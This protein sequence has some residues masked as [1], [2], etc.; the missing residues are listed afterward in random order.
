MKDTAYYISEMKRYIK[1]LIVMPIILPIVG[2]GMIAIALEE[3]LK[4]F[5]D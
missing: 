3:L 4:K 1:I 2:I 5:T